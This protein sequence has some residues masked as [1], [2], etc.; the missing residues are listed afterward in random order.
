MKEAIDL[1]RRKVNE[2]TV[3]RSKD[4]IIRGCNMKFCRDDDCLKCLKKSVL[5]IVSEVEAEFGKDINVRGN[6]STEYINKLSDCSTNGDKIRAMSDEELAEFLCGVFD[7]DECD[8]KYIC[9]ITIPNYDEDKIT[10][11]LKSPTND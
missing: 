9:G 10:E 7:E 8:G 1:I 6:K 4:G 2:I 11:W 5:S 3:D